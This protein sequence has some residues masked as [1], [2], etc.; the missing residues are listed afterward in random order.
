MTGLFFLYDFSIF[1][2]LSGITLHYHDDEIYIYIYIC[3]L[4][5]FFLDP[6]QVIKVIN[7]LK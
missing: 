2:L 1:S 6:I 5:T 4:K 7:Q 3:Y